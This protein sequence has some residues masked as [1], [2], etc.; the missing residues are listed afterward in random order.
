M[1]TCMLN[2]ELYIYHGT[3]FQLYKSEHL[4]F[5]TRIYGIYILPRIYVVGHETPQKVYVAASWFGTKKIVQEGEVFL[6][7][8]GSWRFKKNLRHNNK[9]T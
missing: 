5:I 3:K 9:H 6:K 1:Y 4:Q 2:S 7:S 8:V